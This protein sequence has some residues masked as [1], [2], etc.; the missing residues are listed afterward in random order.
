M[1]LF[2]VGYEQSLTG[3]GNYTQG[4][5][6]KDSPCICGPIS[7][8]LTVVSSNISLAAS[9]IELSASLSKKLFKKMFAVEGR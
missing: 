9:S 8:I 7:S 2:G 6:Y 5:D 4:A 3:M 1:L